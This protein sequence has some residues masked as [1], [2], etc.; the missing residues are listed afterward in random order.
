MNQEGNRLEAMTTTVSPEEAAERLGVRASTL[1]NWR[2]TGSGPR[3]LK[4]GGRVRYRLFDL[5]EWLESCARESTSSPP[6]SS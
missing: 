4:V 2:W 1:A 6:M 3:F 5:A